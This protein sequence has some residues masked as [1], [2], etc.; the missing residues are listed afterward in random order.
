VSDSCTKRTQCRKL[1]R[2]RHKCSAPSQSPQHRK[3][4][5]THADGAD[6]LQPI[7]WGYALPFGLLSYGQMLLENK[8]LAVV[9]DL[10]ETL[11]QALTE[12]TLR[13]RIAAADEKMWGAALLRGRSWRLC[14]GW[15]RRW[16]GLL[17]RA[18]L[19]SR[20]SFFS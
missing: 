10:D 2:P 19:L 5:C 16:W 6:A 14:V 3:Q 18:R 4:H 7:F 12:K 17:V 20:V 9:F 11:L 8:R 15:G 13:E 1:A